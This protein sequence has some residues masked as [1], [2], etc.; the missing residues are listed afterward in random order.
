MALI[1]F[2]LNQFD[3]ANHVDTGCYLMGLNRFVEAIA[4][5]DY[6][7]RLDPYEKYARWG[8]VLARLSLGDY[9]NGLAEHDCAWLHHEWRPLGPVKD[10][11]DR[12]LALPVWGGERC[13]LISYHE[14][15]FG[16]A[17]MLLRFLP[18]MVSRCESVTLV[19]HPDL[20]SL[21]Q[22]YG[23]T[24]V[25]SIPKDVSEFD[26]RVMFFNSIFTLGHSK[27]TIPSAPYI[28]IDFKFTGGKMGITWSGNSRR[29]F[30]INSFLA[31]LDTTG[32]E[33]YALQ[34]GPAIDRV[35][36]LESNSFRETAEFMA[37]MDC[38][39]TIDTSA[40]HLAGAMG[41]PNAHL[42]VPHVRDWRWWNKDVWYPT[43]N[44]YPQENFTDWV[45]PFQRLNE[46][47][48]KSR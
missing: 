34:K 27:E 26:A 37:T 22:G 47:V 10:N 36:E 29:E 7:L 32:F 17:I 16:D 42:V 40:G 23:A 30:N 6:V 9:P 19:V 3:I 44:V 8:R 45:V 33:L 39:V 20:V 41:H 24:V 4:E 11:V 12:I 14:M 48:R 43:L 21:M 5:F 2:D 31:N 15:G 38:V 13:K 35:V 46:A 28:D 1:Y 18:E 25:G